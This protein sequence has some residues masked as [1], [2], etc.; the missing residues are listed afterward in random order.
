V[1][2]PCAHVL[3][4]GPFSTRRADRFRWPRLIVD[5]GTRCANAAIGKK[6]HQVTRC[7]GTFFRCVRPQVNGDATE[8]TLHLAFAGRS[9][10]FM[11]VQAS[12]ERDLVQRREGRGPR[13]VWRIT[14]QAPLGEFVEV[15]PAAAESKARSPDA[16]VILESPRPASWHEST[17]DLLAGV[18]VTDE[19][20]SM[21]GELFDEL[22]NPRSDRPA[23]NADTG[24]KA[25]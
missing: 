24:S 9:A 5:R 17:G 15:D 1:R 12:V 2:K 7:G 16:P 11:V 10:S 25:R 8:H 21:P 22:F 19:T 6:F 20:D 3:P 13:R 18:V 23:A 4:E 14:A